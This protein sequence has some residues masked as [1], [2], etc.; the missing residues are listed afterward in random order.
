MPKLRFLTFTLTPHGERHPEK[1][2]LSSCTPPPL[3]RLPGKRSGF[4]SDILNFFFFFLG[5]NSFR[6]R[7]PGLRLGLTSSPP[8]RRAPSRQNQRSQNDAVLQI[9][10]KKIKLN[11]ADC[12]V[13]NS[14][15]SSG[16][17][18]QR[19]AFPPTR[20]QSARLLGD[21]HGIDHRSRL[22]PGTWSG[23]PGPPHPGYSFHNS[24]VCF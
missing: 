16:G 22:P 24:P 11:K 13:T 10:A 14:P 5:C 15:A 1:P 3:H 17:Q 18:P 2:P 8:P 19:P 23:D 6:P 9:F 7:G 12:P 20:G 4:V 21:P